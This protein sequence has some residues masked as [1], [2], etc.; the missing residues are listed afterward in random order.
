[1]YYFIVFSSIWFYIKKIEYKITDKLSFMK[2]YFP[3][4]FILFLTFAFQYNVGTDYPS[5]LAAATKN[6]LGIFKYNQFVNE[7]EYLFAAIVQ[8]S[9][10][11]KS[12]QLLFVLSS[13]IQNIMLGASIYELKKNKICISDFFVLYFSLSICFFYQF[14]AVRQMIAVNFLFLGI[15]RIIRYNKDKLGWICI[16]LAPL[17]HKSSVLFIVFICLFVYFKDRVKVGKNKFYIICFIAFLLYFAN[18]N[19]MV[20]F[21]INKTGVYT[22]YLNNVFVQKLTFTQ[23]ITKII[24]LVA[25]FYSLYKLDMSKISKY[26]MNILKISCCAIVFM[27]FS[28]SSSLLWRFYL[29]FDIFVVFPILLFFKY[30]A[31]KNEKNYI[32]AY[33][34]F[35]LL[36]KILI[37]PKGEYLYNSIFWR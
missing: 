22:Q 7:R 20:L 21:L 17:F 32:I 27:I 12:P 13:F 30:N 34:S 1:M 29:F 25:I 8:L 11:F 23:I 10:L 37:L 3:V 36:I 4:F 24:K 31:T 9:W 6:E 5:Y 28:F 26:E 14:N 33:L 16:A 2:L 15:L 19:N 35:F 18:I